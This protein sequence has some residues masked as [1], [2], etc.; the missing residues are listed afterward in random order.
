MYVFFFFKVY[1]FYILKKMIAMWWNETKTGRCAARRDG[2]FTRGWS[3]LFCYKSTP[4]SIARSGQSTRKFFPF[5]FFWWNKKNGFS[6]PH[7]KIDIFLI[8]MAH[9]PVE[10][11]IWWMAIR[12]DRKE[13]EQHPWRC[14][15][16]H[17]PLALF[18][19]I[20]LF[21]R[22]NSQRIEKPAHIF[23]R[24]PVYLVWLYYIKDLLEEEKSTEKP[25]CHLL[26][27]CSIRNI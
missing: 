13:I 21:M 5:L 12:I 15:R 10:S 9:I 8:L 3:F 19:S 6:V 17:A 4:P 11:I 25:L 26:L 16:S 2:H 18:L 24:E 22:Q 14:S 27:T 23:E 1:P 20:E 7:Y